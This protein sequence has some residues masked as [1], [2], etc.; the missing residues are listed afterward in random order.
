[1]KSVLNLVALGILAGLATSLGCSNKE[2]RPDPCGDLPGTVCFEGACLE[3]ELSA[4]ASDDGVSG[5]LAFIEGDVVSFEAKLESEGAGS[6]SLTVGSDTVEAAFDSSGLMA[7]STGGLTMDGDGELTA[8]EQEAI[9]ALAES[10]LADALALVPLQLGCEAD[11]EQVP[12]EAVA[13]LLAPWQA[14]LKYNDA[15][16]SETA[17]DYAAR[18]GCSYF[19]N[20][21]GSASGR[22]LNH[23][24]RLGW[25]S[26]LPAVLTILPLDDV[27]EYVEVGR[28]ALASE[29]GP[30]N[31]MCRGACGADCQPINCDQETTEECEVDI[32][33]NATGYMIASLTHTCGTAEGCQEHDDCYDT[34]HAQLGC[35]SWDAAYCRR[36]CDIDAAEKFG[37]RQ[38]AEWA[39]G[40]GP[41]TDTIEFT[42]PVP[43]GAAALAL[44]ECPLVSGSLQWQEEDLGEDLEWPDAVAFCQDLS[45]GGHDDWYL[46]SLEEMHTLT[47]GCNIFDCSSV[48]WC[49]ACEPFGGPEANGCYWDHRLG[50]GCDV[51]W[52]TSSQFEYQANYKWM[53]FFYSGAAGTGAESNEASA[54]CVRMME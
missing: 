5:E 18:S 21:D 9:K 12:P 2:C 17:K 4:T 40:L 46:P 22:P 47:R 23:L 35:G 31:S 14:V 37:Y 16:R 42:F 41:F 48:D 15:D 1:M 39:Q 30:C 20:M 33:G 24:V 19:A 13:A 53:S 26:P 38:C 54:R 6:A 52:W 43:G 51:G 45:S 8:Q 11:M 3:A 10:P 36:G 25:E 28:R 50:G 49:Y 27:G 29:T 7:L 44:D 34:C 32:G